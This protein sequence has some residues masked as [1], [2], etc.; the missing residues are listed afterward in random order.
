MGAKSSRNFCNPTPFLFVDPRI[1]LLSQS[2]MPQSPVSG[3]SPVL[4]QHFSVTCF[5]NTVADIPSLTCHDVT[6]SSQ[7][8]CDLQHKLTPEMLPSL[9]TCAHIPH[10]GGRCLAVTVSGT[11]SR[12]KMFL[13]DVARSF[14][15]QGLKCPALRS[16]VLRLTGDVW[17]STNLTH[18]DLPDVTV[19]SVLGSNS[20]I[21]LL[22]LPLCQLQAQSLRILSRVWF[23]TKQHNI[24]Q[25]KRTPNPCTTSLERNCLRTVL[26]SVIL[27]LVC[28]VFPNV[29][30][31]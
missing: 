4:P 8:D 2:H 10:G 12:S 19:Y 26:F 15:Y 20:S 23:K 31:D 24:K 5:H 3:S 16:F 11:T 7:D 25:L 1:F 6:P 29:K 14:R 13:K 9:L 22:F 17:K 30:S 28:W 21:Q 27:R 18:L